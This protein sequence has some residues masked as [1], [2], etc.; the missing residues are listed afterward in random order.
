MSIVLFLYFFDMMFRMLILFSR[1]IVYSD[2]CPK[3]HTCHGGIV[4]CN[5]VDLIIKEKNKGVPTMRPSMAPISEDDPANK[6]FCGKSWTE[7]L[8]NCSLDTHC[9]TDECTNGLVCYGLGGGPQAENCH[10]SEMTRQPTRN[11]SET[12]TDS[13]TEKPTGPTIPP[14][15][16]PTTATRAPVTQKPTISPKP[17]PAPMIPA[18]DLRHSYWCGADWNDAISCS[19]EPCISGQDTECPPGMSC[20]AFTPCRPAPKPTP[21]PTNMPTTPQPTELLLSPPPTPMIT[22]AEEQ[23]TNSPVIETSNSEVTESTVIPLTPT[24]KPTEGDFGIPW[25]EEDDVVG[26]ADEYEAEITPQP[27]GKPNNP[28]Q[29]AS[30][31]KPSHELIAAVGSIVAAAEAGISDEVLL[32]IDL[33]TNEESPTQ[34]YQYSGF[35]NALGL[36]SKGDLGSS[37][38]YL[39]SNANTESIY[40]LV[41]V[42]LFLSQAAVET[43]QFDV[44]DE[45]SWEKDVFNRYPISNSCGQGRFAGTSAAVSYEDANPCA[46]HEAFMACP[47]DLSMSAVAETHGIFVGAPPP[48][49]CYPKFSEESGIGAWDP[50]LSC[51][52]DGCTSYD[53]Q[54]MGAVDPE[55]IPT[56]NSFGRTDVEGCCWWGRGAFPRGSAGTCMIGRINYYLGKRAYDEGRYTTARYKEL[57]FCSDPSVICRGYYEDGSVNAEIRWLMGMLYWIDKVQAYD[58]DGWSYLERLHD[59]VDGGMDDTTF[60]EVVS[61]IVTRGCHDQSSCG[62]AVMSSERRAKFDKI[63]SHFGQAHVDMLDEEETSS[64]PTPQ[65][66]NPPTIP[67]VLPTLPPNSPPPTFRPTLRATRVQTSSPVSPSPIKIP[68][69]IYPDEEE[70]DYE[71][72][73][74]IHLT[75]SDLMNRLNFPNSYCATSEEHAKDKCATSLRTCNAGDPPCADGLTCFVNMACSITWSD[76]ELESDKDSPPEIETAEESPPE[77]NSFPDLVFCKGECLRPLT[78]NECQ[79]AGNAIALLLSCQNVAVGEICENRVDCGSGVAQISNCPGGHSV[80]IRVYEEQCGGMMSGSPSTTP[81]STLAQKSSPKP[82]LFYD[83]NGTVVDQSTSNSSVDIFGEPPFGTDDDMYLAQDEDDDRPGAW[84]M[85]DTNDCSNRLGTLSVLSLLS[86]ILYLVVSC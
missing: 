39:G 79:A 44:C 74:D 17:T 11:P 27:T 64:P 86:Q 61:R 75:A 3:G 5:L 49:A 56:K 76:V 58:V 4:Q 32:S 52:D 71:E 24:N 70:D 33:T 66:V 12:P 63:M 83:L 69:Y 21:P 67:P 45:I 23:T 31:D 57:D 22:D 18:D 62:N 73:E 43:V 78:A 19:H 82:S 20:I 1:S 77:V 84:W 48:L 40:G 30:I 41:N 65:P 51:Q 36:V 16:T 9:P 38:F 55:S 25:T 10:A 29:S 80:F 68:D 26:A 34:L 42:G 81:P 60:M 47:V 15:L 6:K 54:K 53:G 59:F 2:D 35:I 28:P 37:F 46:G 13:P 14:S 85:T 50:T 72:E 8:E 7:A